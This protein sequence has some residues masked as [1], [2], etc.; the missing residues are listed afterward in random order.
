MMVFPELSPESRVWIYTSERPF[1][2]EERSFINQETDKFIR[3]WAAHGNQLFGDF[4]ILENRFLVLCVDE[5]K[6][7]A[8]GCSIDTSVHFIKSIGDK[9]N[10]NFFD[11]MLFYAED[12]DRIKSLRYHDIKAN[13]A[14]IIFN[15][16]VSTNQ[17]LSSNWKIRADK[18]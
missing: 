6:V 10:I 2:D 12:G 16:L 14:N 17:D 9:L 1:T 4:T 8:S 11:R 15:S 3:Q 18:F 7:A 5:N 13:P